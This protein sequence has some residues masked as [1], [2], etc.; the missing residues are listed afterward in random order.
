MQ[1]S[2]YS[3]FNFVVLFLLSA[4]A[5]LS[6]SGHSS[7]GCNEEERQSLLNF[8]GSFT[9][10]SL[11]LSSWEGN[12]CCQW[13]GV[14]CSNVTG[15]VVKLDL[16]NPCYPLRGQGDFS[17]NC[18]FYD[19]ELEAQQVHPSIL[20]LKYLTYL[21]LSGNKFHNSSIPMFIQSLEH[22]QVLSLSDSQFSGRIPNILGNLTKLKLLD[23]SFNTHLYAYDSDWISQLSSLQYL[24]MTDVYLGKVQ[25]LLQVLSMHPSLLT[26]EL[27]NC[28]LNELQ[29]HN[30]VRATNVSRLQVLKLAHNGLEAQSLDPFHNMTSTTLIDLAYNNLN[31]TPF[32]LS[33][34]NKLVSLFL[35]NN[36]FSG[37]FPSAFQNLSSLAELELEE[38]N[39]DSIPSW[40]GKLK[41]LRY[42]GLSGN[43]ISHIEGSLA[44][45]MGNCCHLQ[46]LVLSGNMISVDALGSNIQSGCIT[47]EL[48]QLYINN[49]ELDRFP[50]WLTQLVNL[51][52]LD[53]SKNSIYG[54][55]PHTIGELKKLESLY[56]DKNNLHGSIPYSLGQLTNLHNL[57]L[58]QNQLES[59]ISDIRWPKQLVYLNL[60]K[61]R[62]MGSL[63]QDT[64]DRLPN[65]TLLLL[66]NNLINGSIPISLCKLNLY[67]LDLSGNMLSG[68]I[69]DCW[70]PTQKLHEI[71]LSSNNLSGVIPRSFGN[72]PSL[73]WLHLNNNSL[74]GKLPSSLR[75]LKNILILD[76]GENHIS[77]IIPSWIG[78]VLSSLQILRLRQNIFSGAIPSQLCQLSTLQILDLS[79]NNLMGLIPHCIGN[80]TGMI[81]EKKSC[82]NQPREEPQCE[83]WYEQQVTQVLK[84]REFDYT[85]NLQLVVN[86]DLSNN[87]F[88]GSIPEEISLLS[89]M[90]GLNLSYN[91]LAG[92]I[93]TKIGNMKSLE[94]LDLS[95]NQLKGKISDSISSLTWLSHLNLSYNNLSGPIPKGYQL[96]SLDDPF[97]YNGNPFLCGDPL[98]KECSTDDSQHDNTVE[99]EDGN[100]DKMENFWF[101][102]V[103]AIGY[104]V[105]FWGVIG[106]LFMSRRWRHAYFQWT[107]DAMHII[108]VIFEIQL[109]QFKKRYTVN[110]VDE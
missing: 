66:G 76:L 3:S 50:A 94:S 11:R 95:H 93:P 83:E 105:G 57:G 25:N 103:I 92:H 23:L 80:F 98:P 88:S 55:I 48:K 5:L 86:M 104:A 41:G 101:Y 82:V 27:E 42:L 71:N 49:N 21:D 18:S 28:R 13:K 35:T 1:R 77:G 87:N 40:L 15:N 62:I 24:Y 2:S 36:A 8:K 78:I 67:N 59:L 69:P 63:P 14:S 29:P 75:N 106:S 19:S 47:Y 4:F 45:I 68:E 20:H 32:W 44:S 70:R 72:L 31:S 97:I 110:P 107:D 102:S 17:P 16:R 12:D 53:L 85:R 37:S 84:G 22:L 38:N 90:Q 7:L 39:F 96:S 81:S 60:T 46:S 26:I 64:G 6:S 109:G 56:L 61:N 89:A 91:N 9:D 43:N 52:F 34:C 99:D 100:K 65:V 54:L 51:E 33:S 58:S 74:H 30:L 108:R 73:S 10:P 79:N